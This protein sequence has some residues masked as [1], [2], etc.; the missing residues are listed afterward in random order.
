M[1]PASI[2]R[3]LH[4]S[5]ASILLLAHFGSVELLRYALAGCAAIALL[6]DFLRVSRPALGSFFNNL[7][8]VFR[9]S[10]SKQLSGATWLCIGYAAAAWYPLPAATAG[11]LAGA[12][13]DPAASLAGSVFGAEGVKKTWVGS[14]TAA[15]V[16]GLV[17]L[18]IGVPIVAVLAGAFT[19]MVLE[20]WPGPLNDNLVVPPGVALVVW[21]LV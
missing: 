10:E 8:P 18:P 14:A 15:V 11:I 3:P 12:F 20:R 2:R 5:T 1:K 7:V 9:A 13:A 4:A 21:L 6:V 19:A 17:L 16:A